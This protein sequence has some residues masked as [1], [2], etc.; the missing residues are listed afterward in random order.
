MH[1]LGRNQEGRTNMHNNEYK[2][3]LS[4]MLDETVWCVH[5]LLK[6]DCQ[7]TITDTTQ[8]GNNSW[9]ITIARDA[10]NLCTLGSLTHGRTS[11]KVTWQWHSTSS[12]WGKRG[13]ELLEQIITSDESRIHFHEPERKSTSMAWKNKEEEVPRKFKNEQFTKHVMFMAFWDCCALLCTEFGLN[14]HKEMWNVNQ[15]MYFDFE[16]I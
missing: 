11:K 15:D 2:G 4:T 12:V 13:N 5:T 9:C 1:Y 16:C 14:T 6:D 3:Q 8:W 7:L 10:K